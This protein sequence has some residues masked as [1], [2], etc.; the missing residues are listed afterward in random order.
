MT[1]DIG[2]LGYGFG[3]TKK[4]GRDKAVN[5]IPTPLPLFLITEPTMAIHIK[6][7]V[8]RAVQIHVKIKKTTYHHKNE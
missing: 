1:Y 7:N 8:K 3:Q 5:W 2:N 4:C 6:T